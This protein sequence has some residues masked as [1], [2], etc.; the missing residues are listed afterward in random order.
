MYLFHCRAHCTGCFFFFQAFEQQSAASHSRLA[1]REHAEPPAAV[2]TLFNTYQSSNF[3]QHVYSIIDLLNLCL[4][5]SNTND[6]V[7]ISRWSETG[8]FPFRRKHN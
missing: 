6:C 5:D 7:L 2:S 8:L 4:S 3:C 1:V